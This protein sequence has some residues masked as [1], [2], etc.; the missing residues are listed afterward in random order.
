MTKTADSWTVVDSEDPDVTGIVDVHSGAKRSAATALPTMMVTCSPTPCE[1]TASSQRRPNAAGRR[2]GVELGFTYLGILFVVAF[3]GVGLGVIGQLW[4]ISARRA[5][6]QQLLF[7]GDAYRRAIGS[8]YQHGGRFP[9]TLDE[10]VLDT[11]VTP[12]MHHLRK[13]YVD[14]SAMVASGDSSR[15]ATAESPVSR[16]SP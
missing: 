10:L 15:V 1:V 6:E 11:R 16:V 2:Y 9:Q 12:P 7:V 8:Y 13:L 14:P 3:I 5:D 4:S